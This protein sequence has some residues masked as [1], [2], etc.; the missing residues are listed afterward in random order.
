MDTNVPSNIGRHEPSDSGVPI[1]TDA[2]LGTK[3]ISCVIKNCT[4]D[5]N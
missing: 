4:M 1:E 3:S 2:Q 5:Y